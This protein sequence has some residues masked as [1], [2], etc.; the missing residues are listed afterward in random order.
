LSQASV[1][2][3]ARESSA[4]GA[5]SSMINLTNQDVKSWPLPMPP[6]SEQQAVVKVLEG[7][8]DS[9]HRLELSLQTQIGLLRER[10]QALITAAVTGQLDVTTAHGGAA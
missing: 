5:S 2:R 10:R 4:T 7:V 6:P 9:Q 8:R 1:I 3:D